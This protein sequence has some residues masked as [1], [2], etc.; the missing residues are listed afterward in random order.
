MGRS[1]IFCVR[2]NFV[3]SKNANFEQ[4]I[5]SVWNPGQVEMEIGKFLLFKF[6]PAFGGK[7]GGSLALAKQWQGSL[8]FNILTPH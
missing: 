6:N 2:L 4:T 5:G 8:C 7:P 3:K 1:R